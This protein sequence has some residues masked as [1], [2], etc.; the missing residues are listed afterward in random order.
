M[1]TFEYL[2]PT[3]LEDACSMLSQ[4]KGDA[5]MIAGGQSLMALLKLMLISS[6]YIINIK[7]LDELEYIDNNG[8]SLKIGALTTHRAIETSPLVKERFPVLTEAE[9]RLAQ[10]Q[11]RNW[12]TLGGAL[13]HA[14]PVGDLGPPIMALAK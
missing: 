2:D 14:D 6:N 8:D 7:N 9:K 10:V 1:K 5:K 11:I 4:H 13:C 12:G 3:S